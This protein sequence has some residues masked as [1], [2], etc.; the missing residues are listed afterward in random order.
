MLSLNYYYISNKKYHNYNRY[1]IYFC[2]IFEK[3]LYFELLTIIEDFFKFKFYIVIKVE[4]LD[5]VVMSVFV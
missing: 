5:I 2:F 1:N 4:I 3:C